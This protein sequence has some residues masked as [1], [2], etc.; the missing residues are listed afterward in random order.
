MNE[1]ENILELEKE[2]L[3]GLLNINY[4]DET[5]ASFSETSGGFVS[6]DIGE[7]AYKR[8]NFYRIFPFSAPNQYI[9]VRET[10]DKA[11]EIGII[12]DLNDFSKETSEMIEKQLRIR[13]FLPKILRIY[14]IKEEY[15]YSYWNVL[16]D[17]GACKFTMSMGSGNASKIDSKR[18]I[19]K[20]IDENRYEIEDIYRLTN[21]ELKKLDLYI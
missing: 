18:V 21:K 13:Y 8:V 10:N 3:D 5:I 9:S 4:L 16:T 6:L 14:S 15:G 11:T 17:K 19:I 20:D 1:N 2:K 7:K 12:R